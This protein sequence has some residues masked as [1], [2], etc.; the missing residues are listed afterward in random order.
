MALENIVSG[1]G[2]RR[3]LMAFAFGLVH[4]FG[5]SFALRETMQFAGSHL[6]TSLLFFNLGV[7]LGQILVVALM[8]P[9]LDLL[10]RYVVAERMG[11][12]ILSAIVAHT[13]WHWM[14]DRGN[15]L[16]EYEWP[17]LDAASA[18]SGL[19]WLM[20]I[21]LVTGV[22]WLIAG[23]WRPWRVRNKVRLKPDTTEESS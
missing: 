11:T 15:Q 3:W 13:G 21:V 7:E 23:V 17:R 9:A 20:L 19:R 18:A 8:V 1:G 12:I 5:F 14:V 4:G 6:L 10:F 22:L 16:S 2:H